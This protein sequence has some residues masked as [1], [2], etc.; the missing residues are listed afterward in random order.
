MEIVIIV[1][2]WTVM[3]KRGVEDIWHTARGGTPPRLAAAKARRSS[4]AAGRYWSTLRD[5]TFDDML[6][7]HNARRARRQANPSTPRPRG[8]ATQFFAGWLQDGRRAAGRKWESGWTRADEKRREKAT[9]PRPGQETVPGEV[10]PNEQDGNGRDGDERQDRPQDETEDRP[11]P[12]PTPVPDEDGTSGQDEDE[13]EEPPSCPK[14]L[15]TMTTAPN[16]GDPMSYDGKGIYRC[17]SCDYKIRRSP[18]TTDDFTQ[19]GTPMTTTIPTDTEVVS[20]NKAIEYSESTARV[21]TEMISSIDFT[22]ANLASGGVTGIALD[23]FSTAKENFGSI[24]TAMERAASE[25]K[26]QLAIQE[27]YNANPGAGTKDFIMGGR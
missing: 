6:S 16:I 1:A 11:R 9:R 18:E 7:K 24:A 27:A 3:V 17:P 10:V 26:A 19:E 5:D 13:D 15:T 2:I 23:E 22:Q 4:G 20:L 12:E 25:F 8:A 21:A 14:C